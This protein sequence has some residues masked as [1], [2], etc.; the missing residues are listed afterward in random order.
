MFDYNSM[1]LREETV[2]ASGNYAI[3]AKSRNGQKATTPHTPWAQQEV[4][5]IVHEVSGTSPTLDATLQGYDGSNWV[6]IASF[7][8]IT[9]VGVYKLTP[10]VATRYEDLRLALTVGG[11]TPSF[12]L[13]AGITIGEYPNLT[14]MGA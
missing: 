8:Q 10:K 1:F 5:L 3:A 12:K 6:N 7:P 2:T 14:K 13:S 4:V 11:T 9:A